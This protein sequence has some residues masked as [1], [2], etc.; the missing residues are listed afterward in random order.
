MFYP[1]GQTGIFK[2]NEGF[3][4]DFRP[5]IRKHKLMGKFVLL[6]YNKPE[7]KWGIYDG[8]TDK[9][10]LSSSLGVEKIKA[11]HILLEAITDT[12]LKC[13]I[14]YP[15]AFVNVEESQ[16]QIKGQ[17]DASWVN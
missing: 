3:V 7:N 10:Y 15:H 2:N 9:Y 16:I 14:C 4:I 17:L 12:P 5:F 8:S 11:S 13:L 6:H 1:T